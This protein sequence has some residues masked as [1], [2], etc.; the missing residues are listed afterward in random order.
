ML[1]AERD[2]H[3][4]NSEIKEIEIKRLKK[5]DI[6]ARDSPTANKENVVTDITPTRKMTNRER[7]FA[8]IGHWRTR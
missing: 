5:L 4:A 7:E 6:P 1:M 3:K 2:H 8:V